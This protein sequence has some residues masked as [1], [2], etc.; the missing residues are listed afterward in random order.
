MSHSGNARLSLIR[1]ART[2]RKMA[3]SGLIYR[4]LSGQFTPTSGHTWRS[5]PASRPGQQLPPASVRAIVKT[6]LSARSKGGQRNGYVVA[7]S[8]VVRIKVN[9]ASWGGAGDVMVLRLA[10]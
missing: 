4:P 10:W 9:V 2:G 6:W 3:V 7:C 5:S 1:T 8:Q